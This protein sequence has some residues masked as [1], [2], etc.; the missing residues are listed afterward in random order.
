MSSLQPMQ[1]PADGVNA[2]QRENVRITGI[3]ARLHS[4]N[5]DTGNLTRLVWEPA[6]PVADTFSRVAAENNGRMAPAAEGPPL[7]EFDAPQEAFNAAKSLQEHLRFFQV[8]EAPEDDLIATLV[9]RS[10]EGDGPPSAEILAEIEHTLE[11][12]EPGQ[13]L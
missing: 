1:E 10:W 4:R 5:N 11:T 3:G 6:G 2:Y 13:Y 9:V 7:M 12:T 8:E